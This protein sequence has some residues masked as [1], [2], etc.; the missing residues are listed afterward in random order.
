MSIRVKQMVFFLVCCLL[1]RSAH[2][3]MLELLLE[4]LSSFDLET[5][6]TLKPSKTEKGT[7]MNKDNTDD[8]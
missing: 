6:Y 2:W 4:K 5:Y 3:N 8:I 1:R 7:M